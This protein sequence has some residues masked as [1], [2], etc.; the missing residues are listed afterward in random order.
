MRVFFIL[1]FVFFGY[2]AAADDVATAFKEGRWDTVIT[3][4]ETD[5]SFST[6]LFAARAYMVKG[7]FLVRG[8]AAYEALSATLQMRWQLTQILFV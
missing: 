4:A 6:Q 8:D 2:A 5:T 7:S 1:V 3:A